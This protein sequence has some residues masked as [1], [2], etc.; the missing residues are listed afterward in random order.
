MKEPYHRLRWKL[1]KIFGKTIDDDVFANMP[2]EHMQWYIYNLME[3]ESEEFKKYTDIAE[4]HQSFNYPDT[5]KEIRA[6]RKEKSY[7]KKVDRNI[8]DLGNRPS[9]TDVIVGDISDVRG[10]LD[11]IENAVVPSNI[12]KYTSTMLNYKH[13]SDIDLE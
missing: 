9:R 7:A 8:F 3:D 1:C 5:V 4:Y 2:Y 6:A 12:K 13:W 10:M 11:K